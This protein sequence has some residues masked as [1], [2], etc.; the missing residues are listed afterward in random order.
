MFTYKFC[1]REDRDNALKLQIIYHRQRKELSLYRFNVTE[2]T[3]ADALSVK[4]RR[5]NVALHH[6]LTKWQAEIEQI[7][8]EMLEGRVS[9][10]DVNEIKDEINKCL[11]PDKYITKKGDFLPFYNAVMQSKINAGTKNIYNAAL[12][13][14][15]AFVGNMEYFNFADIDYKWLCNFDEFCA[16]DSRIN[17]RSLHL[18]T[19]KAV[20][21]RA[22]D[23]GIADLALYPFRRFKI[24]Q[25]QTRHRNLGVAD[26][27]LLFSYPL[28]PRQ[29]FFRDMFVLIFMLCGINTADLYALKE[30]TRDGRIEYKRAKTGRFYSIKVE[31]E[32]EAI[33][34]KYRGKKALIC[35]ADRWGS[36]HNFNGYLNVA[37]HHI[38]KREVNEYGRVEYKPLFADLTTYCARHS[39][40]TIAAELDIPKEVI[41]AALGHS[42]GGSVTDIYI[43][44]DRKKIDIANRKVLD[45]VLYNKK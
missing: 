16:K 13:K 5:E 12:K 24:K 20:Y 44:F 37:L 3:L 10:K 26:L 7:R 32:A 14:I 27:R 8:I 1:I 2:S 31:A 36:V 25:E 21:N 39:W 33:I 23:Q 4:P 43:N 41:A 17:T 11:F 42:W 6:L 18:R 34:N 35:A 19:L 22:I 9:Y 30:I 38:G 45:Y 15:S 29:E 40:A 28:D